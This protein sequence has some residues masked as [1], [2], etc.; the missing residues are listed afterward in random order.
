MTITVTDF[1]A[2]CLRILREVEQTNKPVEISKQGK[3]RFRLI[4]VQ[5]PDKAPWMRL[6]SLGVLHGEPGDSVFHE[7]D[8]EAAR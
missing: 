6:R 5:M 4:P 7:K 8:W 3:V 2:H 1:K